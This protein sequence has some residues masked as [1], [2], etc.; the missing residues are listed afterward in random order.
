MCFIFNICVSLIDLIKSS[1]FDCLWKVI[2]LW[3]NS[4]LITHFT[5]LNI[6]WFMENTNITEDDHTEM[7]GDH[8]EKHFIHGVKRTRVAYDNTVCLW[9]TMFLSSDFSTTV[10]SQDKDKCSRIDTYHINLEFWYFQ[11]STLPESGLSSSWCPGVVYAIKQLSKLYFYNFRNFEKSMFA[12]KIP[13]RILVTS[14]TQRTFHP[15]WQ[16]LLFLWKALS[17]SM[18]AWNK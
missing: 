5:S 9:M 8:Y 17:Y 7:N 3:R 10:Q 1:L 2:L 4:G 14:I 16:I 11:Q 6:P 15:K 13:M 18:I 12:A